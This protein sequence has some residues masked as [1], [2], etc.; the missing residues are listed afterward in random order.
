MIFKSLFT[1]IYY[2]GLIAIIAVL[3]LIGLLFYQRSQIASLRK[4]QNT[5]EKNPNKIRLAFFHP[6]CNAGGGGEKVLWYGR[7]SYEEIF[8]R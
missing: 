3:A 8:S 7:K 6:K 2:A 1:L 5:N 4:L